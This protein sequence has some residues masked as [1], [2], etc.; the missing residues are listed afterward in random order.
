[1][2]PYRAAAASGAVGAVTGHIYEERK[3]PQ[4]ADQPFAGTA[5]I[6]VP[7]S[8]DVLR[9]LEEIKQTSRNSMENYRTAGPSIVA[10]RRAYE[11]ELWGSGAV[12]MVKSAT[13]DDDVRF[14][15]GDIHAVD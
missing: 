3:K 4:A 8:A 5:V 14:V 13:V 1:M 12:D 9:K 11:K 15:L 2:A 6:A 10:L 7:K